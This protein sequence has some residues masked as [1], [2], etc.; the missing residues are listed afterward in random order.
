MVPQGR[1]VVEDYCLPSKQL[2]GRRRRFGPGASKWQVVGRHGSGE[3]ALC[4]VAAKGY[5]LRMVAVILILQAAAD[6]FAVPLERLAEEDAAL[7]RIVLERPTLSVDLGPTEVDSSLEVYE[8]CMDELPFTGRLAGLLSTARY[9]IS[10]ES[11]ITAERPVTERMKRT[12]LVL[13]GAGMSVRMT[14][15]FHEGG[16]WI[17]YSR[18]KYDGDLLDVYSRALIVVNAVPEGGKLRTTARITMRVDEGL[19]AVAADLFGDSVRQVVRDKSALF[20]EAAR[21]VTEA[22]RRD[23]ARVVRLAALDEAI[24]RRVLEAFRAKFPAGKP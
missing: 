13:D 16:R 24:D 2:R 10:R 6:P 21:T 5:N 22:A 11:Q 23:P 8:F 4:M 14:R 9:D 3:E 19:G 1:A 15:V 18:G 20:I 12:F 17:Y 7:A